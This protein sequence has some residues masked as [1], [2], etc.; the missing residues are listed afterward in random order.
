[1]KASVW[2]LGGLDCLDL[3]EAAESHPLKIVACRLVFAL[4]VLR[5][6]R[7]RDLLYVR[8]RR[9]FVSVV[10]DSLADRCAL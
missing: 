7:V 3:R 9:G 8:T 6:K 1:M 4:L 5:A 10:V 2:P